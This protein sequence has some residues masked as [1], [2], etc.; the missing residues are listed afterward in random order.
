MDTHDHRSESVLPPYPFIAYP[1]IAAH[2]VTGDRR[3][4]FLVSADG[5]IDWLCLPDYDSSPIFGALLDARQGGYWRWGPA[6]LIL[7][8]Q[9][10]SRIGPILTTSWTTLE[11]QLEVTDLMAWPDDQRRDEDQ[12]RRA[13][14]RR[15]RCRTGQIE[16]LLAFVPQHNFTQLPSGIY[17]VDAN[18]CQVSIGDDQL[19]LWTTIPFTGTSSH[20]QSRQILHAGDEYWAVLDYSKEPKE[21]T[22]E[23]ARKSFAETLVAWRKWGHTLNIPDF[24]SNQ[25]RTSGMVLHLLSYAPSGSLVAAPT[26]SL[27]ECIGG[28]RNYDYRLCW[29]RDTSLAVAGLALL[30][31]QSTANYY[32]DWL[33]E[34]HSHSTMPYQVVYS[35]RGE[36]DLREQTYSH[37]SGYRNSQPV[38]LGNR[39]YRQNQPGSL[40]YLADCMLIHLQHGGEWH[41]SYWK[42]LAEC[43]DF[44]AHHW[45]EADNGIWELPMKEHYVSSNVM[46]W[47]VLDRAITIAARLDLDAPMATWTEERDIIRQEIM[48]RGWN[49]HRQSFVQRYGS[50]ALDASTLLIP[51]MGFLPVDHPRVINMRERIAEELMI[52]GLL[53][54]FNPETSPVE[55]PQ[56]MGEFEGA[57]LPCQFWLAA[58][59]AMAG[60]LEK[61]EALLTRAERVASSTG[62]FAEEADPRTNESL[63]NYPLVFSQVEYI[64]AVLL[65][66]AALDAKDVK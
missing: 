58:T 55:D 2:G 43:A 24:H 34:H 60:Q 17:Q 30:G 10:Y 62:L 46:S 23:L 28:P 15:L 57:F 52:D 44:I 11:G 14:L 66:K 31:D 7:G 49:E 45:Q 56:L 9:Q 64:R 25:I 63:G 13:I 26:T 50:S 41:S 47:V 40:G 19:R 33:A 65:L 42:V 48:T 54:R 27:P 3:T 5:T 59:Y 6:Q 29:V 38:R 4:A 16:S 1:S 36:E 39:A 18:T 61:A 35:I 53:Y 21:W 51:I 20:V 8:Q 32:L 22:I 37:L 12:S